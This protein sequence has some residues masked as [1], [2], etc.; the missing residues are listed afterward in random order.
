M[1]CGVLGRSVSVPGH[2]SDRVWDKRVSPVHPA[3]C[4]SWKNHFTPPKRVSEFATGL[5]SLEGDEGAWHGTGREG[6]GQ[7]GTPLQIRRPDYLFI[8]LTRA[9]GPTRGPLT[10]SPIRVGIAVAGT[11]EAADQG[12]HRQ[13]GTNR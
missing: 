12:L 2:R 4:R 1:G 6:C 11:M 13:Q 10:S 9:Q 8:V 5:L 7:G 3:S